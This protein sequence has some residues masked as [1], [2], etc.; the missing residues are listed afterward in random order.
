MSYAKRDKREERTETL[1][2]N[3]MTI[4]AIRNTIIRRET[5]LLNC[6]QLTW[7]LIKIKHHCN[8]RCSIFD[9]RY[10]IQHIM[11]DKPFSKYVKYY[12]GLYAI[13]P[14]SRLCSRKCRLKR[15]TILQ[16][17]THLFMKM[18]LTWEGHQLLIKLERK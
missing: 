4:A 1:N 3:Q 2:F 6:D 15:T 16:I 9:A 5:N 18:N 12:P 17:K 10:S 14:V 11:I 7:P 13:T 8:I